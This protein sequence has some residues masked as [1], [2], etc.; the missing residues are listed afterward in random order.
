M[1]KASKAIYL[2]NDFCQLIQGDQSITAYLRR[3]KQLADALANN[4][5]PVPAQALVL[6][7]SV[8]SGLGSP[9][10]TPSSP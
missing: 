4:D 3:Q 2:D 1:N 5:S 7:T 6:N 8:A 10:Q 9:P